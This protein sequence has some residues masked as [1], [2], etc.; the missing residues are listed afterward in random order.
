[1][2]AAV[3]VVNNLRDRETDARAGKRTL[4]VRLGVGGSRAEYAALLAA[5][6]AAPAAGVWLAGWSP[7]TLLAWAGVAAAGPALGTVM[8]SRRP[9]GLDRAL[10]STG[11]A[12]ALYGLLLGVGAVL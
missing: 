3:L 8:R 2:C 5:G 10:I 11:R 9:E 4:A 1:M 12:L 7:W 6:A